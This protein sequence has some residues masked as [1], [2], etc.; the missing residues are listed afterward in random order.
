MVSV[1]TS[2]NAFVNALGIAQV[3]L[4][5]FSMGGA[6]VQMVALTAPKLVRRLVLAGTHT[7][8]PDPTLKS[9]PGI[10]WPRETPPTEPLAV[11]ASAVTPAEVEYSLAFS[12]FYEDEIDRAA[13]KAG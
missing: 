3:D 1:H 8:V 4:L 12:F 5:G 10:I 2:F 13:A 11:L 6:A 7:S 9:I